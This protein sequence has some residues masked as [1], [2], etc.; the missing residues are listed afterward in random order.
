MEIGELLRAGGCLSPGLREF[1]CLPDLEEA[2]P[3]NSAS[4]GND[5]LTF[6]IA[7]EHALERLVEQVIMWW[8]EGKPCSLGKGFAAGQARDQAWCQMRWACASILLPATADLYI[9][10]TRVCLPWSASQGALQCPAFYCDP[11]AV[12]AGRAQLGAVFRLGPG[13]AR[14]QTL[15]FKP[16]KVQPLRDRAPADPQRLVCRAF[17]PERM[18]LALYRV[19]LCL[20]PRIARV[21]ADWLQGLPAP[22]AVR[23]T[24]RASAVR[25]AAGA[26]FCG[27]ARRRVP[28]PAFFQTWPRVCCPVRSSQLSILP[29]RTQSITHRHPPCC[30]P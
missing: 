16:I 26:R 8:M 19:Q 22:L 1:L 24:A 7:H 27:C 6:Y 30:R 5:R 21:H 18:H 20:F 25:G 10:L 4:A 14:T 3:Q 13:P 11:E 17:L 28:F 9:H 15:P 12:R 23:A 2:G 29:L